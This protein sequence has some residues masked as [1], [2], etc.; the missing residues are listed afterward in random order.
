MQRALWA[1]TDGGL[2]AMAAVLFVAL[3]GVSALAVEYGHGLLTDSENQRAADLAAVSG[4]LIY[5]STGSTTSMN[6][7]VNNV[8]ALNGVSGD[9]TA[10]LVN[11]PSGDGNQAVKV[12]VTTTEPLNFAHVITASTSLSI[13]AEAFA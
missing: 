10:S 7:A 5:N 4:A 2:S 1:R 3:I 13:S 8:A 11:S 6:S 9:A 12:V